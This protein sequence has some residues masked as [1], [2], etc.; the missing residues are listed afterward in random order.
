MTDINE[1]AGQKSLVSLREEFPSGDVSFTKVDVTIT[2][3]LVSFNI[4]TI[5][6]DTIIV[7]SLCMYL[8]MC[9]LTAWVYIMYPITKHSTILMRSYY[10]LYNRSCL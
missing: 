9:V 4:S 10:Y 7:F 1:D 2:K 5:V 6:C 8:F 3:E